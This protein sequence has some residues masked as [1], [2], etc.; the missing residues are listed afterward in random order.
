MLGESDTKLVQQMYGKPKSVEVS[1][2]VFNTKRAIV[3]I[4]KIV[5]KS[6][7]EKVKIVFTL[8]PRFLVETMATAQRLLRTLGTLMKNLNYIFK[9]C[10][11]N[12]PVCYWL[13]VSKN[14][15]AWVNRV[16]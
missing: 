12:F 5:K 15:L 10:K 13:N 8:K 2:V 1:G 14:G 16:E 3:M 7:P 9:S 11:E 4:R 6:M